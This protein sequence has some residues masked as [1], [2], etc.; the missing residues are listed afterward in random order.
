MPHGHTDKCVAFLV[1]KQQRKSAFS[2]WLPQAPFEPLVLLPKLLPL[3]TLR[4]S[5]YWRIVL[6]NVLKCLS[7]CHLVLYRSLVPFV[8]ANT[9]SGWTDLNFLFSAF[10]TLA[11]KMLFT[12]PLNIAWRF[13]ISLY[14]ALPFSSLSH[15][16]LSRPYLFMYLPTDQWCDLENSLLLCQCNPALRLTQKQVENNLFP[17]RL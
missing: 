9:L 14:S 2:L 12:S 15:L 5:T 6:W 1:Y 13:S 4:L 17:D 10:C 16:K 3:L 8:L 7:W 11:S